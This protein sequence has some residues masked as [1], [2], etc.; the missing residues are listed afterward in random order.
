MCGFCNFP[1]CPWVD[2]LRVLW[3]A[4]QTHNTSAPFYK[5]YSEDTPQQ[6]PRYSAV[7][8]TIKKQ[9]Y[10]YFYIKNLF[11]NYFCIINYKLSCFL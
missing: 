4:R 3:Y 6:L 8:L 2:R 11:F 10:I 1:P 7:T 5:I 9:F